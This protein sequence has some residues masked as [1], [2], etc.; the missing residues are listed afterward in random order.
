MQ[1]QICLSFAKKYYHL[2]Q[3]DIS[4]VTCGIWAQASQKFKTYISFTV[5]SAGV[6]FEYLRSAFQIWQTK[7]N[8]PI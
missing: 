6:D 8:F 5:H 1:T 4:Q 3:K 7:F 2:L